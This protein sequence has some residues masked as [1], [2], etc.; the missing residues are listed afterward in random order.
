MSGWDTIIVG[1]GSAGCVLAEALSRDPGHRVLLIESGRTD[2]SPWIH[3]PGTFFKVMQGGIDAIV[4]RGEDEPGLGGRPC[5]VPQGHVLGG[6]SS[7]N[8]M[9]YVRGQPQDYDAWEAAGCTGW[10]W[11][12]VRPVFTRMEGNTALNGPL[13]GTEGPLTVSDPRHRHP[14]TRAFVAAAVQAGLPENRDFNGE[15]QEGVG[16]YQTTTRG[17]R[18][19]SAAVAFLHPARGRRNLAILTGARVDRVLVENG[20]ACGV[21]LTD[22][23]Q[24]DAAHEVVLTAGALATPLILMRSGIGPAADLTRHGIP[25]LSDRPGV[26]GNYQDHM[27]IPIEAETN[28]PLSTHGQDR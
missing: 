24:I 9:L 14:L 20:R 21:R 25:V 27:A 22:G 28:G 18:R 23:R 10:G 8:A 17:G 19:C 5:L 11:A 4:Y 3:I 2:H 1:G 15:Q 12:Q 13:H 16:F 26:G 7:V 6:G